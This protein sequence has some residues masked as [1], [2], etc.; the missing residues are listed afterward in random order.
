[1]ATQF[2][3]VKEWGKIKHIQSGHEFVPSKLKEYMAFPN[4]LDSKQNEEM[5]E[6]K[7]PSELS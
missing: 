2:T 3:I 7:D 5:K 6:I 1:M 4:F